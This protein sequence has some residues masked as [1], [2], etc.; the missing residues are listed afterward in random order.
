[1]SLPLTPD[2]Q[3]G[4]KYLLGECVLDPDKRLI[5]RQGEV[6][7]LANKPFQVLVYLVEN[8]DRVVTR[9][10]LLDRFWDGKD[11]YD[12]TLRKSVGAIRK[13]LSLDEGTRFI[14]TRHREGYR[15][16]G[17]LE[18]EISESSGSI[19]EVERTRGVRIVIKEED[20]SEP[21]S[22]AVEPPRVAAAPGRTRVFSPVALGVLSVTVALVAVGLM[23]YRGQTTRAKHLPQ[24][25]RSIAVLPLKNLSGDSDSDYFADGLTETFITELSRIP[26]LRVIARGSVFTLKGQELDSREAGRRL[27]VEAL[28]EGSVRRNGDTLRV[29]TRLVRA[30]DGQVIWVGNTFDRSLTDIF[31]VQDEISCSVAANLKA[32]LCGAG[33]PQ[34]AK[35]YTKNVDA[36]DSFLRARYFYNQRTPNGLRK[37]IEYATQATRLDPNYV[38]AYAGLAGCYLMGIWHIP[39]EPREAIAKARAAATRAVELDDSSFEAHEAMASILGYEWDWSGSKKEWTRVFELNPAYNTYGYA[40]S[41]LQTNPQEA[42]RW[43][44][45]AED[46]DPLSLL[47]STNVGQILFYARR[48]DDAIAQ[49]RKV[50]DLDANYAMAHVFLGQTY[51]EKRMYHDAI[52]EFTKAAALYEESPEIVANLGYAYASA[53]NRIEAQKTLAELS[54]LS[55]RGYVPTYL[56]AH[57]YTALGNRDRA[58]E[59]LESA[60]QQRDSHMVDLTYDPSLESLRSDARYTELVHR[61]GPAE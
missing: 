26:A 38:S 40:Y 20:D 11:V 36:Y 42:V 14:E 49:L 25:P 8:R 47:I 41:L 15:Y 39:L 22:S 2:N 31:A 56:M 21:R 6:V 57:I 30:E 5:F 51:V 58:F 37:A 45:Q 52:E 53:G 28:L 48:Y 12:D 19:L 35:R 32:S 46:L 54:R 59:M 18:E 13:A 4:R 27:G 33:E 61:V 10:E 16:V 50:I 55:K 9:H 7:R 29:E 17:P 60:Y 1:M 43:I 24:A 44:K 3:R 23:L 34:P